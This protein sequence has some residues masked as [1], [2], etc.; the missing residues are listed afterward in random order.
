MK[1]AQISKILK[2]RDFE[3]ELEN[4]E[5]NAIMKVDIIDRSAQ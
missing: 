3:S 5:M 1:L 4:V 2:Q